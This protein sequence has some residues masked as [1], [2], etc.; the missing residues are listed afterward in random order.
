MSTE[1]GHEDPTTQACPIC[2]ANLRRNPRYPRYVCKACASQAVDES[3]RALTFA[4]LGCGFQAAYAD[5]GEQRE[6]HVCYIRG[7]RCWAD[8]ARFG[9]VVV[10]THESSPLPNI[11]L[12]RD[13]DG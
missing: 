5:T 8:E 4:G 10:Q 9:G 2:G 1:P 12:Q 13:R 7:V 6:S 3:G 11:S